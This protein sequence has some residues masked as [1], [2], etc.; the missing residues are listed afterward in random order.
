MP[1]ASP[2]LTTFA[3]GLRLLVTPMPYA[4]SASASIYVAAGS[5][6][7]ATPSEGGLSHF[8]EHLL[9]K[10]TERRPKPLD[11]SMEIDRIGGNIN[12]A[13][14]RESTV[15]Y[16]K[17]TPEYL[18]GAVDILSDMVRNS[19]LPEHEIERERDVIL[20][21]LAAV[22][23]S[24]PEQVGVLI[25]ETLWPGQ[26]HGRDIAGTEES[27]E[28]LS[29]AA[30]REY[31]RR[32]YVPN[33]TVVSIAGA[34]D[35]SEVRDMVGK[36]F[37][38]WR[39]GDPFPMVPNRLD[40]THPLIT[41]HDKDTEQVHLSLGLYGVASNDDDRYALDLLSVILGEG[42][43]SR[44]F[45]RLREEL[46][47]CYDIH[48]YM[49]TLRDCGMFGVYAGVDPER[50]V[51]AAREIAKELARAC[52]PVSADE[53]SRAKA[54]TRS[55]TQLRLEDSRSVSALYGSQMILG[56]PLRTPEETLARSAA[57][58]IEEVERVAI[59]VMRGSNLHVAAVGQVDATALEDAVVFEP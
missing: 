41:L 19:V 52:V 27:V 31:Y 14:N 32:Q 55:R 45:A 49:A 44:L 8:L 2:Q 51:E 1:L 42:M 36:A 37:E 17:V 38:D 35:P 7:E 54:V 39:R 33:S 4:R 40:T 18:G 12:A 3:N 34:V 6:Y 29:A 56:L 24:P 50:A 47:L 11:I 43:S 46:A 21:E 25:D 48:S 58:S 22:E 9:F 30:I 59:R 5:R 28:G 10:G 53:L 23:D 13:T 15:Y 26:P 16:A 20:E 57:V